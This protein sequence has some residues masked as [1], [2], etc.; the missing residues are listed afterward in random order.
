MAQQ[1]PLI[2]N[3]P[4]YR[5]LREGHIQEFNER[6]RKGEKCDLTGCDFHRVD[7]RGLDADGLDLSNGYFRMC[8]LRG[9]DLT[10]ARLEGASIHGAR[11]A[12]A[13]FPKE[14]TAE[15]ITLSLLHGTRMRYR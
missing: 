15:E 9:I 11:I 1:A 5:L 14:L 3:D 13:F 10:K 2:K 4:L 8:D 12:G 6:K 7:L